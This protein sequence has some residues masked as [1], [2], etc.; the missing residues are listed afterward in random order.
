LSDAHLRSPW[1]IV[2]CPVSPKVKQEQVKQNACSSDV[3]HYATAFPAD[4][5]TTVTF[6]INRRFV[7]RIA[8]IDTVIVSLDE[9]FVSA[10]PPSSLYTMDFDSG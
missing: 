4:C 2:M 10:F 5:E 1:Y 7:H 3:S 6:S 9:S 8:L